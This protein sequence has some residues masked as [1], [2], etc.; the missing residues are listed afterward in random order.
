M[1]KLPPNMKLKLV[2][3]GMPGQPMYYVPAPAPRQARPAAAVP[4]P[5]PQSQPK[6]AG[7]PSIVYDEFG[8]PMTAAPARVFVPPPAPSSTVRYDQFGMPAPVVEPQ[9][10]T[11][12]KQVPVPGGG[13]G[14]VAY[15]EFGVPVQAAP[16]ASEWQEVMR[17][18]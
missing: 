16:R 11:P 8:T 13:G 5:M 15:N 9:Y 12:G 17:M 10:F 6:P 18:R 7:P 1:S 3:P 4:R 2:S 14:G